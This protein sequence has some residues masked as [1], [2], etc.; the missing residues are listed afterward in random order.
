M[1]LASGT[2]LALILEDSEG[3]QLRISWERPARWES[4]SPDP[5]GADR[6]R[7]LPAGTY[8]IRGVRLIDRSRKN[9]TW[10]L[11]A[12]GRQ[13]G[14]LDVEAGETLPFE[15]D[16][17]IHMAAHLRRGK[18]VAVSITTASGAGL[19]IYKDWRRIPLGYR[20]T[21]ADGEVR[22]RGPLHYG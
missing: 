22:R 18:Q 6:R 1:T 20:L 17:T 2:E 8:R 9:E 7:A 12:S 4:R 5:P 19:S 15:F 10:H 11:S 16:P 14:E 3:E 13:L 21:S